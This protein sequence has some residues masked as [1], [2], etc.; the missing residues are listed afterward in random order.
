MNILLVFEMEKGTLS[1]L[2][3]LSGSSLP[4]SC[5]L[6]SPLHPPYSPLLESAAAATDSAMDPV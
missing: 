6:V 4:F 3:Y 1:F 2:K 5:L